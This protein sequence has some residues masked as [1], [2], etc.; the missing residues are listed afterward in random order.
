M[1]TSY[2]LHKITDE[3][4]PYFSPGDYSRFKFGDDEVAKTFGVSLANGFIGSNQIAV[5]PET[6]IVV[7]PSPY[8]YIPTATFAMKTHF[9]HTL[10]S[11]LAD[12]GMPVVQEAKVSRSI[13]YKDDYGALNAEERMKLIGN[14]TFQ[15]DKE[16][17]GNKVLL[18][19]DDI[20][21]TGS[22]EKMIVK[23]IDGY[24]LSNRIHLLYFAE[25][26]NKQIH[27][28]IEN[29]LNYYAVKSV[30]DI[31]YIIKSGNFK[32]NTR[33]VKYIL[34]YEFSGFVIF[35]QNQSDAFIE[36]LYHLA[37]G[38]GYHTIEAYAANLNYIKKHL[39]TNNFTLIGHG[40]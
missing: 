22:H 9:V 27:P 19:L 40:N 18:F 29:Y 37:I 28:N 16:F 25:L 12:N 15:I 33:V 11:W 8:S 13:T 6:Q 23:M 1:I 32:F 30:F 21:I 7:I 4:I 34:N 20:K 24:R 31:D 3:N 14:D 2:A 36:E 39:L 17:I 35:L 10:N 38:N 26:I 5:T